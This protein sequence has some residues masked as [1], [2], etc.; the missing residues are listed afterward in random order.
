M[1]CDIES[2]GGI[3]EHHV[4][5]RRAPSSSE[6]LPHLR[7]VFG[8]APARD[9]LQRVGGHAEVLRLD[10]VDADFAP[11]FEFPDSGRP[12]NG[13][14]VQGLKSMHNERPSHA[15]HLEDLNEELSKGQRKDTTHH[16]VRLGWVGQRPQD[17]ED[18]P[19][20]QL[21]AHRAH[22][23]HG[24]VVGPGKEEGEVALCQQRIHRLWFQL[25]FAS[26]G[27]KDIGSAASRR[28]GSVAVLHHPGSGS[29]GEDACCRGDVEGVLAI[30]TGA[31]NVHRWATSSGQG[32]RQC[33]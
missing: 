20:S 22:E 11:D 4:T 24:W 5:H 27:L 10:V 9:L 1:I 16:A 26:Q 7:C 31:D 25:Q 21:L 28:R 15:Q 32:D 29:R 12:F 33:V 6:E 2:C 13:Q 19:D 30:S 17:V 23:P 18:G 8:C 14:L 3:H